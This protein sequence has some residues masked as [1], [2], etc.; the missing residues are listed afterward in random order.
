MDLNIEGLTIQEDGLTIDLDADADVAVV[1]W[2]I[3]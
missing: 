3:V 2:K 1:F